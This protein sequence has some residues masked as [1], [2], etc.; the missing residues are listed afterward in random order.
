LPSIDDL[1]RRHDRTFRAL[2]EPLGDHKI[3]L[4]L[5]LPH[6]FMKVRRLPQ[7]VADGQ[8]ENAEIV[9]DLPLDGA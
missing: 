5:A 9:G 1:H 4:G 8:F 7:S 2:T 3:G 6:G